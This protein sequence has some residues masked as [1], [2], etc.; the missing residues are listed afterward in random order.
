MAPYQLSV[1]VIA[2]N[3]ERELPR[4]LHSLS[5]VLQ[6]DL[7]G[8]D[9]EIIVI[10]NGSAEPVDVGRYRQWGGNICVHRMTNAAVSP[11]AAINAG[12]ALAQGELIGVMIDGARAASPGLLSASLRAATLHP[13]PVVA[14]LGFHLGPDVQM[15][16]TQKGYDQRAEDALLAG[17]DWPTDGYRLFD[18]SVFAGSSRE[19]WFRPITES[20]A[21]FLSRP[22]W[23]ELG[24]YDE[25]F[26][27]LGGGLINLDAY[28]RACELP[29]S[30][31][32][33]LLGEGTFHQVHGGVATNA[34]AKR[35]RSLLREFHS[36]YIRVR[37][38]P[39]APPTARPWYFGEVHPHVLKSIELSARLAR[40][41]RR[42]HSL[43]PTVARLHAAT[44]ALRPRLLRTT[45]RTSLENTAKVAEP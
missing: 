19:G 11:A 4:T 3:M 20:N 7:V 10:D 23:Q 18:V 41:R 43:A 32:V 6:R 2:F 14:S 40:R 45:N 21:L 35:Q 15:R 33:V 39:F 38:K 26:A 29:D 22:M 25:R 12:L 24:G 16:S 34:P 31:L 37:G 13:R 36:E 17:I 44:Q 1:V 5:P 27:S 30:Q 42:A 9:Y 8:D 28:V